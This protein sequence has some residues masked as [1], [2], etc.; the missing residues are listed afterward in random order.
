MHNVMDAFMG[1]H[2]IDDDPFD[3]YCRLEI[4]TAPSNIVS[5]SSNWNHSMI[6]K[7][8]MLHVTES[9]SLQGKWKLASAI[10]KRKFPIRRFPEDSDQATLRLRLAF[11]WRGTGTLLTYFFI[12][13][14]DGPFRI[15]SFSAYFVNFPQSLRPL[16]NARPT[17]SKERAEKKEKKVVPGQRKRR[18]EPIIFDSSFQFTFLCSSPCW[19]LPST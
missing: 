15:H 13:M 16:F 19:F 1:F 9:I 8:R 4:R 11:R 6:Y 14:S 2:Y 3:I 18:N 12:Y 7:S 17:I 5:E 10:G